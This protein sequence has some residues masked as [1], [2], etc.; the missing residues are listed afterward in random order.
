[1]AGIHA[2]ACLSICTS[3]RDLRPGKCPTHMPRRAP[4]VFARF[5]WP[6]DT[7]MRLPSARGA[8]GWAVALFVTAIHAFACL[9]TSTNFCHLR[10][11][12]CP[13]HTHGRAPAVFARFAWP[14]DTPMRPLSARAARGVAGVLFWAG[15]S[16]VCLPDHNWTGSMGSAVCLLPSLLCVCLR[17][18]QVNHG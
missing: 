10:P 5:A 2:C 17:A 4:A 1:M 14:T 11:G 9:S 8:R 18:V 16:C 7:P 15:S 6:T 13:T 12:K 3:F